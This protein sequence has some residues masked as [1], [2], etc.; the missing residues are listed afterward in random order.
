[1]SRQSALAL[2]VALIGLA[3]VTAGQAAAPATAGRCWSDWS[4][5]APVVHKEALKPAKQVR[6]QALERYKGQLLSMTLCE[7]QGRFVY[8]LTILGH[9]GR[10]ENLSVDARRP[11]ER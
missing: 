1:M 9:A 3:G 10:V 6:E 5:A 11:F 8:K 7:E 2:L 4:Q